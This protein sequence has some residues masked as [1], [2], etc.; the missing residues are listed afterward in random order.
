LTP[1]RRF[2]RRAFSFEEILMARPP[3]YSQERSDRDRAKDRKKQER[4]QRRTEE[5]EKRKAERERLSRPPSDEPTEQ[6]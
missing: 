4:L 5:S 6:K 2:P 3:N 1:A